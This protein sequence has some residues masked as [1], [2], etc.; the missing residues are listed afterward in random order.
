VVHAASQETGFVLA[1]DHCFQRKGT[2]VILTGSVLRGCLTNR[3]EICVPA[4]G[5]H[6]YRVRS[7]QSFGQP[8]TQA[9]AGARVGVCVTGGL[10]ATQLERGLAAS[11]GR[12]VGVRAFV[13]KIKR[14]RYFRG[15]LRTG[16]SM[17]GT[18]CR[19]VRERLV[20]FV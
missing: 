3:S 7:L 4:A 9:L 14:I 6:I 5:P 10:P 11:P 8:A 19:W 1:Y 17:H 18:H 20:L 16:Q 13:S 15:E 12:L 2:G